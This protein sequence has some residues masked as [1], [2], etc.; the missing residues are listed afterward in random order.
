MLTEAEPD[1]ERIL[2]ADLDLSLVGEQ[3]HNFDPTGHYSRPDVF[4]LTI[5]RRRSA[6]VLFED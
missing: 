2:T 6:T 5:D 3:R 1:V 4:D